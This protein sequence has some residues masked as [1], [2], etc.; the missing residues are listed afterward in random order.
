MSKAEGARLDDLN[1]PKS[2][3]GAAIQKPYGVYRY[4]GCNL[5]WADKIKEVVT[6][7]SK[8]SGKGF[9]GSVAKTTTYTYYGTFAILVCDGG[10]DGLHS[11]NRIW[12]NGELYYNNGKD[13]TG[14]GKQTS[15]QTKD[16]KDFLLSQHLTVYLGTP[17][18]DADPTI[19]G[20][21]GTE[22]PAFRGLC[23]LV[24]RDIPLEKFGNRI[25]KVDVEVVERTEPL[26]ISE[27][28]ADLCKRSGLD[29][30][31]Y[32]TSEIID[33]IKGCSFK[34]DGSSAKPLI[35][36]LQ[37]IGMFLVRERQG[38]LEFVTGH[39]PSLSATIDIS[40]MG[41]KNQGDSVK[42]L[43]EE[44]RVDELELPSEVQIEYRNVNHNHD[45]GLQYARKATAIH[46]N[47]LNI[48]TELAIND[49]DATKAC[50]RILEYLWIQRRKFE[51]ITLLPKW[52]NLVAAE[53]IQIPVRGQ[54]LP[55]QMQEV[56]IGADFSVNLKCA[57]YDG[58]VY[59]LEP[60]DYNTDGG[61]VDDWEVPYY[62][63]P[64]IIP[65]DIHLVSDVDTQYGIY[66]AATSGDDFAG[67]TV[68]GKPEGGEYSYID[69]FLTLSAVG[70]V[71]T[72]Q[73]IENA[74]PY[75]V[76]YASVIRVTFQS[77]IEDIEPQTDFNFLSY[78]LM[79]LV[80]NEFVSIRDVTVI[81]DTVMEFRTFI[82]GCRGTEYAI[83]D[84]DTNDRFIVL[85]GSELLRIEGSLAD[86]GKTFYFKLVPFGKTV[87]SVSN[88]QSI[89]IQGN[90][91]K[92]Y[93]PCNPRLYIAANGD[94]KLTWQRRSLINGDI[95]SFTDV[96][97]SGNP[98]RV[99]VLGGGGG[100][101]LT[102]NQVVTEPQLVF[103]SGL[104]QIS[105]LSVCEV[106]PYVGDGH[107]ASFTIT[108][109]EV[110]YVDSL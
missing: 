87:D 51:K 31:E 67:G 86:I 77:G 93:A 49:W 107:T 37:R 75:E 26:L 94:Q 88:E 66:L 97:D 35:E 54:N 71:T 47:V 91:I 30:D 110:Y 8:K 50:N 62:G 92:P 36:D 23:Y 99:T 59:D 45:P 52:I 1:T 63:D 46:D 105:D 43:F 34:Q 58:L 104:P 85:K 78:S 90:S 72:G 21:E 9:G 82:R 69:D 76:D 106:S 55:V 3:F 56:N 33:T 10:E 38:T 6:K 57:S 81:S 98:Y 25:P 73:L 39:R 14:Q 96:P 68:W 64:E 29:E 32:D 20:I 95:Q 102:L 28:I 13:V 18:Q 65:L 41:T 60:T 42:D 11:V 100:S 2:Q 103:Q 22:I 16:S 19:E 70:E 61:Y 108:E 4:Y 109:T 84:H 44:T 27:V 24:F 89:T 79:A 15:Q 80:N 74:N 12:L 53:T 7:K 83:A 48:R 101:L 17:D 5:F 40:D